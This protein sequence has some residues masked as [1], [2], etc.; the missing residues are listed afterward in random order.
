VTPVVATLE[1]KDRKSPALMTKDVVSTATGVKELVQPLLL[2]GTLDAVETAWL[3]WE[4][5]EP[6]M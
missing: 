3:W 5:D 1:Q 6:P 2:T 4:L